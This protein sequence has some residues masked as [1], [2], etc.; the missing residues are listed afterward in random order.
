MNDHGEY[1]FS[2]TISSDDLGIVNCLRALSQYSQ[3]RGNDRIP[4]GGT[5][6]S[7][8]RRDNHRVTFRFSSEDYRRDFLTEMGRLLPRALWKEVGRRDDD[9]A[10]PR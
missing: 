6:D 10:S 5:K 7:D 4:W 3:K 2:A 8:W 1:R 9:P